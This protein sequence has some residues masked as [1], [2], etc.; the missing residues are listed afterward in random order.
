MNNIS[1]YFYAILRPISEVR[2][3]KQSIN[4]TIFFSMT[5][6]YE[7]E[8]KWWAKVKCFLCHIQKKQAF[9]DV[10]DYII[11]CLYILSHVRYRTASHGQNEE[12]IE[13]TFS[14]LFI[15]AWAI[16][17]NDIFFHHSHL[18]FFFLKLHLCVLRCWF[19]VYIVC[20]S[21]KNICTWI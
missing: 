21:S 1:L 20:T 17:S 6:L 10:Y 4:Q 3:Y 5:L 2:T 14:F 15:F 9:D 19:I 18:F 7:K 12:S 13:R 11:H 16:L 8:N